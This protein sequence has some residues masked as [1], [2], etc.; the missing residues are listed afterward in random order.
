MTKERD[1]SVELERKV[2]E[3]FPEPQR[4]VDDSKTPEF[5]RKAI[6]AAQE[7]PAPS[8][9]ETYLAGA[10]GILVEF[11]LE[12]ERY[13]PDWLSGLHHFFLTEGVPYRLFYSQFADFK[14]Q[15][16][17]LPMVRESY[18]CGV[19]LGPPP[20]ERINNLSEAASSR[21]VVIIDQDM[22]PAL[23]QALVDGKFLVPAYQLGF[24]IGVKVHYN[25]LLAVSEIPKDRQS[26]IDL[27]RKL[28]GRV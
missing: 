18:R 24:M 17:S 23:A 11:I 19:C 2:I 25:T 20:V 15:Y 12:E 8:S 28:E 26:H 14:H 9:E 6:K 3:L 22:N 16:L 21:R 7:E 1:P 13:L 27:I 4:L 10:R 5:L